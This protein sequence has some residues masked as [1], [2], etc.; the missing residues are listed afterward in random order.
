MK[1]TWDDVAEISAFSVGCYCIALVVVRLLEF[2][3]AV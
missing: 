2:W 1:V 3:G